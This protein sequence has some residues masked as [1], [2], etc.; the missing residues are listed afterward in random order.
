MRRETRVAKKHGPARPLH[1][2][3]WLKQEPCHERSIPATRVRKLLNRQKGECTVCGVQV[4]KGRM[5]FC[6]QACVDDFNIRAG[7]A[8]ARNAVEK[9]DKGICARCGFDTNWMMAILERLQGR[10]T[11]DPD[12]PCRWYTGD[13]GRPVNRRG[14]KNRRR[15]ARWLRS[16]GT[17]SRFSRNNW[18][19]HFINMGRL[20]SRGHAWEADHI[21]PVSKGG[22]MCSLD[23][24]QIVCLL[25]HKLKHGDR[26]SNFAFAETPFIYR[27]AESS[28]SLTR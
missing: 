17:T 11:I 6:S 22:G 3:D 14:R 2:A 13:W 10:M 27:S 15:V 19:R 28:R 8:W 24:L 4:P 5:T 18:Q 25:C 12:A 1:L 23:G 7:G 9:R 21:V 16:A 20:D 26:N